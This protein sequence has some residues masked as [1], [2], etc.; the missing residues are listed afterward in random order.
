VLT[1]TS[2]YLKKYDILFLQKSGIDV[3][4]GIQ[5]PEVQWTQR[6]FMIPKIEHFR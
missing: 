2:D 1:V 3:G 6:N 4:Q 5:S